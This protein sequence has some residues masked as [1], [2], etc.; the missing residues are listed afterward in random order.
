MRKEKK[1]RKQ[2]IQIDY[3]NIDVEDIMDQIRSKIASQPKRPESPP[4]SK[5]GYAES[6]PAFSPEPEESQGTKQKLK[7][8][9]LKIMKPFSPLIKLLVLPVHQEVRETFEKLHQTNKHLEFLGRK[10]D[11]LY[12]KVSERISELDRA[13]NTRLD[14]AYED[15]NRAIEYIRLLHNL[16]HNLVVELTKLKIEEE[17]LKVKTR[18]LEKDFIFLGEREKAVEKKVF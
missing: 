18:I 10:H 1:E 8:L 2:D 17:N 14:L 11:Q 7:N 15:L 6:S 9:L 5:A 4:V 3:E 12:Q 16:S 13:V